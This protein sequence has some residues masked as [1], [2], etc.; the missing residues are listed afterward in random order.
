MKQWTTT[1]DFINNGKIPASAQEG[2]I[3]ETEGY[4]AKG[5]GGGAKWKFTGITG[6][7]PSQG[8]SD[9]SD[10]K[11]NDSS[12]NE[13]QLIFSETLLLNKIG[14]T[15]SQSL[16]NTV[17]IGLEY[18]R[19]S[20]V[21]IPSI[22]NSMPAKISL[23]PGYYF[24]DES[25]NAQLLESQ[26][27]EIDFTNSPILGKCTG[28]TVLDLLGSRF[29]TVRVS[30]I[31]DS[32]S[33]PAIGIQHG[34]L[35]QT[36]AADNLRFV[37]CRT[38]GFF[39]RCGVYN[40]ASETELWDHPEIYNYNSSSD[41]YAHIFDG[42]NTFGAITDFQSPSMVQYQGM[43]NIQHTFINGDWRKPL[44]GPTLWMSRADQWKS[45]NGYAVC[46]DDYVITVSD[47][48]SGF[49]DMLFDIHC[50]IDG[51]SGAINFIKNGGAAGSEISMRGFEHIDHGGQFDNRVYNI[52]ASVSKVYIKSGDI[53]LT[54]FQVT[55]P[56]GLVIPISKL[57]LQGDIYCSDS[58][59]FKGFEH[60]GN[61][62]SD[63]AT[64]GTYGPGTYCIID[65]N[66]GKR[67]YKG[68][69]KF[70]QTNAETISG[71]NLD[72]VDSVDIDGGQIQP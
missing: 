2:F 15:E 50:E 60:Y 38:K 17:N 10:I 34:R 24:T 18:I 62:S 54:R 63:D 43:S 32:V 16:H 8:P 30:I 40:L 4:Y 71:A 59:V 14:A 67:W 65:L 23:S 9:L 52:D 49:D 41:S 3:V 61:I 39:S 5:D 22:P 70:I 69:V 35:S 58:S 51:N 27:W 64:N 29:G 33:E 19:N 48:D 37:N 20:D 1:E 45:Y 11:L 47:D 55:P 53:K 36:V 44:G 6:Q 56:N 46:V 72:S 13:F 12:G 57:V 31:G 26:G 28:K 66:S 42:N 68:N 7:T 25:F 21:F